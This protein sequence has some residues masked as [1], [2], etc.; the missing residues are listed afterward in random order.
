M[1]IVFSK[2]LVPKGYVGIALFP[3]VVLR[4]KGF[5]ADTVLV[6]H[7]RIH[8]RQQLEFLVVFFYLWYGVEFLYRLIIHKNRRLAY[9]HI[10]F[11]REAYTHENDLDYLRTRPFWRVLR[12]L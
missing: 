12:Y 8:L 6:N 9:R 2:Y 4:H 5:K 3:F 11:E 1:V 7:E 10:S